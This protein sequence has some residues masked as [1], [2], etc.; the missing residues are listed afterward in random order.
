M[1]RPAGKALKWLL[2]KPG[3]VK[4]AP[5]EMLKAGDL[6][7]RLGLDA[8][9]AGLTFAQTPGDLADKTIAA[10]SQ[11]IGGAGMGLVGG[12][13]GGRNDALATV[14]DTTF[15][16]GGDFAAMPV[17]DA[18]MRG[19]DK[20]AGGEG[21]TPWERMGAKEK[22][23]LIESAQTQVLADLGLLPAE[24]QS[25]LVDPSLMANGLGG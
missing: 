6:A 10:G 11:L 1:L 15:S 22:E 21:L 23:A 25:Y 24:T 16:V 9:F 5:D 8:G 3:A 4:G 12:R 14:L 19:K 2:S 7:M 20:I 13:L 17:A 18:L